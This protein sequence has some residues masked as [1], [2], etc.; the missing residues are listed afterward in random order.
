MEIIPILKQLG[1][2]EKEIKVYLTLLKSGPSSV[3]T[4]AQV[5]GINRGTTYDILKSLIAQGLVSYYN[6]AA[7]QYFTAESPET[8]PASRATPPASR[9][10]ASFSMPLCV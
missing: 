6:K 8:R 9:P 3:R 5:S 10:T 7:H 2:S 1:F 4:L